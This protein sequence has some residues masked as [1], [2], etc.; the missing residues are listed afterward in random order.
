MLVHRAGKDFDTG[1]VIPL[2]YP[3]SADFNS[4][5]VVELEHRQMTDGKHQVAIIHSTGHDF[6][7]NNPNYKNEVIDPTPDMVLATAKI[8]SCLW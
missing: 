4:D 6:P 2:I 1:E 3:S 5:I 7:C 8:P